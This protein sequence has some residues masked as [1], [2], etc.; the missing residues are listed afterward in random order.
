VAVVHC[1]VRGTSK[2]RGMVRFWDFKL[3]G[4]PPPLSV[5]IRQR[6]EGFMLG[7][8]HLILVVATLVGTAVGVGGQE[9]ENETDTQA[10]EAVVQF[11]KTFKAKDIDGVMKVV[12]VPFCREG[13][14]NI[15]ERDALKQ[16]FQKALEIR[17]PSKD[18]ITIMLVTTLPKL[19]ESEGKFT[20]DERKACQA[21][22]GKD[23]RIVKVVRNRSGEG[24]HEALILVRLQKGKAKVVGII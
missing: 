10:K 2:R 6:R 1:G 9:K 16:F 8:L 17:D 13:G 11:F 19:E 18:T 23:H 21:A 22:L 5:V 15:E 3:T 20:D 4:A 14:K 12:D 24:K 7:K